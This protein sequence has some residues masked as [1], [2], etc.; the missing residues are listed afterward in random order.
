M[1]APEPTCE[2]CQSTGFDNFKIDK[3]ENVMTCLKCHARY[4]L[5][6]QQEHDQICREKN[7]KKR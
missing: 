4:K 5:L 2:N 6:S 1:K 7:D 3:F